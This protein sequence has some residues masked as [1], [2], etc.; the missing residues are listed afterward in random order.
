MAEAGE[1]VNRAA[2]LTDNAAEK[3]QLLERASGLDA[4]R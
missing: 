3:A 2:A 1:A 4:T